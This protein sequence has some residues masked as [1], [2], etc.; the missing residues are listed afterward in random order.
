MYTTNC[1][2]CI[3]EFNSEKPAKYCSAK[4][5]VTASRHSVTAEPI[6]NKENLI[7]IL[8]EIQSKYKP[9]QITKELLTKETGIVYTF[10]PNWLR[11]GLDYGL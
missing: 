11:H 8:K 10:I 6:T 7:K 2:Q 5:R 4:C 9:H 3:K 1:G